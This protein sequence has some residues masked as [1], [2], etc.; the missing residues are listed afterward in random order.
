MWNRLFRNIRQKAAYIS[1]IS[2]FRKKPS[3]PCRRDHTFSEGLF[4]VVVGFFITAAVAKKDGAAGTM[5]GGHFWFGIA[6]SPVFKARFGQ[7]CPEATGSSRAALA[8]G[9]RGV[10]SARTSV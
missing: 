9:S 8:C 2:S 10:C 4:V 1:V 7:L 5:T 3:S 6:P